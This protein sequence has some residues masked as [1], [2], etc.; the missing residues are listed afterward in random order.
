[1][2]YSLNGYASPSFNWIFKEALALRE[3]VECVAVEYKFIFCMAIDIIEGL[4][5]PVFNA[6]YVFENARIF[7]YSPKKFY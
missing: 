5:L 1:M 2:A 7:L 4:K 3:I 6:S